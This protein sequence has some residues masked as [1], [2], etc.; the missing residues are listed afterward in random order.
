MRRSVIRV[1]LCYMRRLR[2]LA[3]PRKMQRICGVCVDRLAT[4]RVKDAIFTADSGC[5]RHVVR[6]GPVVKAVSCIEASAETRENSA[7]NHRHVKDIWS[8]SYEVELKFGRN[9]IEPSPNKNP[10]SI[11][12]Y[13]ANPRRDSF[14]SEDDPLKAAVPRAIGSH[15]QC[16][17]PRL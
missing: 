7:S 2:K 15:C 3:I 12:N 16:C 14:F 17:R 10:F 5:N 6:V 11:T 13:V 1:R 8:I 9:Q 4:G